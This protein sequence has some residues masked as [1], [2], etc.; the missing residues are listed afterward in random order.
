MKDFNEKVALVT[1]GSTGIG[2]AT[3]LDFSAKGAKVVVADLNEIEA[4]NTVA[5]IE[6]AGGEA[7]F[8]KADVSKPADAEKMVKETIKTFGRLDYACNNAGIEG[9]QGPADSLS[10]EEW[11]KVIDVNLTGVFLSMKYELVEML[12]VGQGSIVNMASILGQVGFAGA[13]AYTAAK[14][15]VVGLTKVAA[16][17]YSAKGI[18]VNAICPAFIVT[19][20]L[21]RAGMLSDPDTRTYMDSLHPIGRMGMPEE[22]AHTVSFL[23]SDDASFITGE[24]LLVDGGYVAK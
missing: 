9:V 22:I 11:Q 17:D 1:G 19:P 10:L 21:E 5:M 23:C 2:R 13:T 4:L 20:M 16:L 12:K 3:A 8:V 7:I 24:A 15:G 18:R 6:K 14:H